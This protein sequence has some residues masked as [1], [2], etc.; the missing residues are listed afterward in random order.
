MC[1]LN[2]FVYIYWNCMTF[3]FDN[4]WLINLR[5]ML[6][7]FFCNIIVR[8]WFILLFNGEYFVLK[9]NLKSLNFFWTLNLNQ[10]IFFCNF[11]LRFLCI[12]WFLNFLFILYFLPKLFL[13]WWCLFYFHLVFFGLA[14]ILLINLIFIFLFTYLGFFRKLQFLLI[15]LF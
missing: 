12:F 2:I 13:K 9:L 11:F 10:F 14:L 7:S 3:L 4:D 8:W 1:F 15:L 5:L 6:S